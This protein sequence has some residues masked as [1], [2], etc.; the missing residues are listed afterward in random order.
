MRGRSEVTLPIRNHCFLIFT[1]Y[2]PRQQLI[3]RIIRE[4]LYLHTVG[5]DRVTCRGRFELEKSDK[6]GGL[7]REIML[8][9]A[10]ISFASICR[11]KMFSVEISKLG[12][13]DW[14]PS[15]KSERHADAEKRSYAI[16]DT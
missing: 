2:I 14:R 15:D 3:R 12:P 13:H 9:S 1:F 11:E 10:S 16:D 4:A 8:T 7:I 6:G 5:K